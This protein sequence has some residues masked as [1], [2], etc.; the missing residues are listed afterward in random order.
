MRGLMLRHRS[1]QLI[2]QG[3]QA[4]SNASEKPPENVFEQKLVETG[5]VQLIA[6]S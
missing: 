2:M 5:L 4:K 3:L 6:C 1:Q